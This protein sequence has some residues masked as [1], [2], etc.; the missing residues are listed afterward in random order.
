MDINGAE[1]LADLAAALKAA[2]NKELQRELS[3]GLNRAVKPLKADIK[4]SALDVLPKGGGYAAA[5]AASKLATRRP[6][7]KKGTGLRIVGRNKYSLYHA[8]QGI[9]RHGKG[10]KEQAI[11]PGWWTNPT[12]AIAP[13]V[14]KEVESAM[15]EVAKK[16]DRAV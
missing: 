10:K 2:G 9:I 11:A 3:K 15:A 1:Q 7:N 8:D 4:Q 6:N 16:I 12:E 13:E 14:R 5:I